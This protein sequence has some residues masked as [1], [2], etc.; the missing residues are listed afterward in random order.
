MDTTE[1]QVIDILLTFNE[2]L[3]KKTKTKTKTK[4]NCYKVFFET[5]STRKVKYAL[6]LTIFSKKSYLVTGSSFN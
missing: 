6:F 2:K 4:T 1:F 5:K 3:M